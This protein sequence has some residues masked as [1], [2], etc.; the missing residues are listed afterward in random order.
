LLKRTDAG[1][2]ASEERVLAPLNERDRR[3]LKRILA[4]FD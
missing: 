2:R 1:V 3:D 4:V